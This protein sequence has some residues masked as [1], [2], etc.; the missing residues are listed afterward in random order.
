[1][2]VSY[3]A[4]KAR[5]FNRELQRIMDED[6]YHELFPQATLA[7]SPSSQAAR[8]SRK[9]RSQC[10]RVRDSGLSGEFQ[11]YRSRRLSHR[12]TSGYTYHDDLY[13]DAAAAWSP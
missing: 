3:N 8:K 1:M 7:R 4:T 10:R 5:K 6:T 13:K 2:A 11:D 12:R 9:L